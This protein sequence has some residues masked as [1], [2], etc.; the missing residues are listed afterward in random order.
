MGDPMVAL[1]QHPERRGLPGGL[2][3]FGAFDVGYMP[4]HGRKL[5]ARLEEANAR[6]DPPPGLEPQWALGI[7]AELDETRHV[8]PVVSIPSRADTACPGLALSSIRCPYPPGGGSPRRE[9]ACE[10]DF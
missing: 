4:F 5:T 10:E 1:P 3:V 9:R 8:S 2:P 6:P 7:Y